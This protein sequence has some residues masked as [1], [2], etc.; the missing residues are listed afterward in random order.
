[1]KETIGS[2]TGS[3]ENMRKKSWSICNLSF[4]PEEKAKHPPKT[5]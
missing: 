1:M 5:S 2:T 4:I 3:R